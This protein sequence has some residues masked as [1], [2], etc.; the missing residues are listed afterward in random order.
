M[1][2]NQTAKAVSIL[3]AAV[4]MLAVLSVQA[5]A[6]GGGS[7]YF[8]LGD[9]IST[10]YGLSSPASECF[11]EIV[12]DENGYT[13]VNRAVNGYT[14]EDIYNQIK[15]GALDAYITGAELITVTCGG[16]DMMALL[17]QAVADA[18][19]AENDPDIAGD[20]VL[21]AF[22]GTHPTLTQYSLMSYAMT[23]LTDFASTP[24]YAEGLRVYKNNLTSVM[25][26][27][28]AK[29]ADATVIVNTQ[30]NPY[31][32]LKG[33]TMFGQLYT[34]VEAGVIALNA[35]IKD[36]AAT[37]NYTVA[38]VYTAFKASSKNL[39]NV[40]VSNMMSPNLD[41]HPNASGHRVIA[42]TVGKLLDN[43]G[44]GTVAGNNG[45]LRFVKDFSKISYEFT[46]EAENVTLTNISWSVDGTLPNG[47]SYTVNGAEIVLGGTPAVLTASAVPIT[48][49]VSATGS[50]GKLYEGS[51]HT[52][53][54]VVDAVAEEKI[55][56][57]FEGIACEI[58]QEHAENADDALAWLNTV[59]LPAAEA[60]ISELDGWIREIRDAF[61]C[62][63][64]A[65]LKVVYDGGASG[66]H[67]ATAGDAA[68]PDG[69]DGSFGPFKV[70]LPVTALGSIIPQDYVLTSDITAVIKATAYHEHTYSDATCTV[71]AT[72]TGCGETMGEVDTSNHTGTLEKRDEVSAAEDRDGYTGDSYCLDCGAKVATG[73]VIPALGKNTEDGTDS[74]EE[75]EPAGTG[76]TETD[77]VP[78]ADEDGC[79]SVIG[80]ASVLTVLMLALP[81]AAM[82]KKREK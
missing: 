13:L 27:I 59:W 48:L 79:G 37:L 63:G 62:S 25:S 34:E 23:A 39:G 75:T 72:C 51:F 80:G 61:A 33:H 70:A 46:F 19:N 45:T 76:Q 10:G 77:P 54:L 5:F 29:N 82:L 36:N 65:S 53:I 35:V 56:E 50:D 78:D 60:Q 57:A 4:L 73:E 18:Y 16:N 26:Y 40:D 8:A 81:A 17:Y 47:L 28:R 42:N 9:S 22:A 41:F 71:P 49:S 12:A 44:D 1:K 74:E 2:H 31:D 7:D 69:M 24:E 15:G 67:A 38:D 55:A 3:L 21:A 11:V 43:V 68:D 30:Y 32:S 58:P 66:F 52:E 64:T 14:A 6:S 20:D